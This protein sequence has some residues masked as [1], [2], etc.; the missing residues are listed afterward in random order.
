M[1]LASVLVSVARAHD[2]LENTIDLCV[3]AEAL[4]VTAVLSLPSALSLLKNPDAG[5][6][7]KANFPDYR[8]ALHAA[9]AQVCT[10]LDADGKSIAPSRT[11]VSLNRDGEVTYF[12]EY[13]VSTRPASLRSALI[14]SLGTG[15]FFEI[16]DRTVSPVRRTAL[17]HSKPASPLPVPVSSP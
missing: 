8:A 6:I 15:Y 17:I 12:F 14:A 11:H 4:E 2:P 7:T 10:L 16:T 1:L 3:S 5:A 13:P 9:S